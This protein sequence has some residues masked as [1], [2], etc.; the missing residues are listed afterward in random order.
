MNQQRHHRGGNLHQY[1]GDHNPYH[2]IL[3]YNSKYVSESTLQK[4]G[5]GGQR[6]SNAGGGLP[7]RAGLNGRQYPFNPDDPNFLSRFKVGFRGALHVGNQTTIDE[8]NAHLVP[9]I[10]K[11]CWMYSIVN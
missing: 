6:G 3:Y 8:S 2:G 7:T 10:L 5:G 9:I 11:K 4:Y 1:K